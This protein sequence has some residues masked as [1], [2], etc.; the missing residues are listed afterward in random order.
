MKVILTSH[1]KGVGQ[2]GE[3]KDVSD[4]YFQNFLAPRKLAVM[5]TAGKVNL[6]TAQKAKAVEKLENMKESA[7]AVKAKVQGKTVELK[8]KSSEGEELYAAL[9][10]KE[11][12]LALKT[13]LGVDIPE[14][15]IEMESIKST[16]SYTLTLKLYKDVQVQIQVQVHAA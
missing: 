10:A 9:H 6:V 3:I 7:L 15:Q 16:G 5:A 4:G 12:R 1:I 8:G 2:K 13:Q 14:K 11:L